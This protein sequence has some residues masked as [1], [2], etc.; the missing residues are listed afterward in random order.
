LK[1]NEI[2]SPSVLCPPIVSRGGT[3]SDPERI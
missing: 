2:G 3:S 1:A